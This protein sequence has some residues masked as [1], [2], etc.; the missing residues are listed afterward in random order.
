MSEMM[1]DN[2]ASRDQLIKAME[3]AGYHYDEIESTPDNLRFFGDGGNAMTM[4]GWQECQAWLNG[5]VFDDPQVSDYVETI[6][7]PA[8][9][10][11][12][13]S[14]YV[15]GRPE[16]NPLRALEDYLE[17]NDN[18][19]DGILNNMPEPAKITPAQPV[20]LPT[21]MAAKTSALAEEE[22]RESVLEQLRRQREAE[23]PPKTERTA[24][25]RCPDTQERSLV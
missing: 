21:E 10:P 24:F 19:F 12:G 18:S 20:P 1:L 4:A 2:H 11:A 8:Q 25:V 23:Y 15:A 5:V 9:I 16:Q 3:A 6:L 13:A 7:H 14:A 17:Q 22:K